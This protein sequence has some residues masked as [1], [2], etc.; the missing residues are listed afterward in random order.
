MNRKLGFSLPELIISLAIMAIAA[1]TVLY[2]VNPLTQLAK[3]RNTRRTADVNLIV[4]AIS[5]KMLDNRG[6]FTCGAGVIPAS[7]TRMASTGGSYDVASC[8]VP[9][10]L[11]SFPYDGVAPNGHFT[12][13]ADYLS[14]YAISRSAATG[15][16]TV[17]PVYPE[18]GEAISAT[19]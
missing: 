1:G 8:L 6:T 13:T 16:I 10:Y 11:P 4:N 18:L 3:G 14:G 9:A 15:R 12:G 17:A 19:R 7:S 2:F 5:S